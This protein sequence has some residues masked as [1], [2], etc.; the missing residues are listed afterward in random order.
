MEHPETHAVQV[1]ILPF[2]LNISA[3]P[4]LPLFIR[5]FR[6]SDHAR[7]HHESNVARQRPH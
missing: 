2:R 6:T 4:S 7:C 1:Q 3:S 5:S